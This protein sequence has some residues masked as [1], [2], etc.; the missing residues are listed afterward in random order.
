MK[1]YKTVLRLYYNLQALCKSFN[2]C[3]IKILLFRCRSVKVFI[4]ED[5]SLKLAI[6]LNYDNL[7]NISGLVIF[8]RIYIFWFIGTRI[9]PKCGDRKILFFLLY[10]TLEK[11]LF[12]LWAGM[13]MIF[14][15]ENSNLK[16]AILMYYDILRNISRHVVFKKTIFLNCRH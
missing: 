11:Y 6:L 10:F 9:V 2:Q 1:L 3:L 5:T 12:Y 15:Y 8:K 4:Y 16:L 13:L 7:R 14:V